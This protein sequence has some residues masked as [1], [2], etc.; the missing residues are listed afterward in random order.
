MRPYAPGWNTNGVQ[1]RVLD[2]DIYLNSGWAEEGAQRCVIRDLR[3]VG[4][5]IGLAN[6]L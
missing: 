1:E 3:L 6:G 5:V 4:A 2:I